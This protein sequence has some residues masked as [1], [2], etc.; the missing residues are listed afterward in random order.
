M[1]LVDHIIGMPTDIVTRSVQSK[2]PVVSVVIPTHNRANLLRQAIDSVYQQEGI[3][4]YFKIEI[5]IV[6]DASTDATSE[7]VLR[8]PAIRYIELSAN[9]GA[10]GARNAGIKA[11][12]GKYVAFLDDDDV[13]LSHRL[14][15]QVPVLEANPSIGVVYGHGYTYGEG[16]SDV[17]WPDARW[18]LSGRVF[19]KFLVQDTSD[20][21]NIDTVLVRRE[22]FDKVGYFDEGL[23][24]LEHHDMMLRLAFHFPFEFIRGPVSRGRFSKNGK[25]MTHISHGS[26]EQTYR[27]IIEKA[28]A[29]LP[30]T[31]ENVELCREARRSV[32]RIVAELHWE[33][34]STERLR[35]L[36][37]RTLKEYPWMLEEPLMLKT[38]RR[39]AGIQ[40]VN[41]GSPATATWKLWTEV[42]CA[43][44]ATSLRTRWRLHQLFAD[45]LVEAG[46]VLFKKGSFKTSAS[47]FFASLLRD[48]TRLCSRVLYVFMRRV[49]VSALGRSQSTEMERK[50][51]ISSGRLSKV[52][53]W[54]ARSL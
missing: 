12:S 29:L 3:G 23:K 17:I 51:S 11:S 32:F 16:F 15:V 34:R 49:H 5:I 31:E 50:P 27:Q 45:L 33:H 44:D 52:T 39:L 42:T 8:Y 9:L 35:L 43:V 22:A 24:T 40:I 30:G 14:R 48:P 13:W 41:A 54:L 26:Y 10:A 38:L 4:E 19:E 25:F 46:V 18:G 37:L 53:G 47:L 6:N 21:F 7:I 20:V 2:L 1:A 36:V 28:V